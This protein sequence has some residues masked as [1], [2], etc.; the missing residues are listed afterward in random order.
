MNYYNASGQMN[1]SDR[2]AIETGICIGGVIQKNSKKT[3]Q[4][5]IYYCT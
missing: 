1:L 4:T 2:I 3:S 5:S